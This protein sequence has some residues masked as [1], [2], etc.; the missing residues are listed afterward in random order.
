MP[1]HATDVGARVVVRSRVPGRGR[2][3]GAAMTDVVGVLERLDDVQMTVRRRNGSL[4]SVAVAAVV[5]AHR[6]P[7]TPPGREGVGLRI[8]AAELQRICDAGWPAPDTAA[9]GQWLLRAAGGFTGRAN[10]A[11]VHGS[12]GCTF[13]EALERVHAF[14]TAR[15][16][17][18]MAQVVIGSDHDAA[19]DAAGWVTKPGSHAGAVVQVAAL[20]TA[21][22]SVHSD[23]DEVVLRPDVDSDWLSLYNRA[24]GVDPAVVAEVV[25]GP[26]Q[27]ALG[28]IGDPVQAIGRMVVTGEWAGLSAVEVAPAQ[29]RQG[30]A[31]Q[32]VDALLGWAASCGARWCY[33]QTMGH[34]DAALRLYA[35]YGFTTHHRYRYV[36]PA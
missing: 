32:L 36:V 28:R 30:R 8:P 5:T 21:L 1:L 22:R 4:V 23:T 18:P 19:F 13:A 35:P 14:Y 2:S 24:A 26:E 25:S 7:D 12:P 31:R 16:L 9:L 33:L 10:S 3:G 29:R 6:V 17:P 34:N 20:R 27:V 11:S 15:G